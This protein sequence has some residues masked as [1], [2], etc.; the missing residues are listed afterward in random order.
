MFARS[1]F[2]LRPLHCFRFF[3]WQRCFRDISFGNGAFERPAVFLVGREEVSVYSKSSG[4]KLLQPS[5]RKEKK[6]S[7]RNKFLIL[8]FLTIEKNL[9]EMKQRGNFH[10]QRFLI[11][12][13]EVNFVECKQGSWAGT[14]LSPSSKARASHLGSFL[15]R[16]IPRIARA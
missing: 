11:K 8:D 15:I 13:K 16:L 14:D 9:R 5:L 7:S 3:V 2:R 4:S 12:F 10:P 6:T 1:K